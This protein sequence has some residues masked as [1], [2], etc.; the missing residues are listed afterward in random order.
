MSQPL[1]RLVEAVPIAHQMSSRK[2]PAAAP[3][4]VAAT[5]PLTKLPKRECPKLGCLFKPTPR[6]QR[7]LSKGCRVSTSGTFW[8]TG[9]GPL[10]TGE[11]VGTV[12][13]TA[14]VGKELEIC[15]Q[16]MLMEFPLTLQY[17]CLLYTSDAADE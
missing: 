16:I 4:R 8:T 13:E 14:V 7:S 1:P 5:V 15:L 10:L 17:L 3:T 6:E 9:N 11:V 12:L 2:K